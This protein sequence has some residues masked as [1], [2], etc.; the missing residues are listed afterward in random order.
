[1]KHTVGTSPSAEEDYVAYHISTIEGEYSKSRLDLAGLSLL[2]LGCC[3]LVKKAAILRS[4]CNLLSTQAA[5]G[6]AKGGLLSTAHRRVCFLVY[7][8]IHGLVVLSVLRAKLTRGQRTEKDTELNN[9]SSGRSDC[10]HLLQ[11]IQDGEAPVALPLLSRAVG[12]SSLAAAQGDR[13]KVV[14]GAEG[15]PRDGDQGRTE[16]H[17]YCLAVVEGLAEVMDHRDNQ[18]IVPA[19]QDM[20]ACQGRQRAEGPGS[21]LKASH[22][23]PNGPFPKPPDPFM[24]CH[25]ST[26]GRPVRILS[27][28][29]SFFVCPFSCFQIFPIPLPPWPLSFPSPN[30]H[31]LSPSPKRPP[32]AKHP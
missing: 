10:L 26:I 11:R 12:L 32:S 30:A 19:A 1:M 25:K 15:H 28:I 20:E 7:S 13:V 31:S 22:A 21:L 8:K 2:E 17:T 6:Q 24:S 9:S 3:R 14:E 29:E 4:P 18:G 5:A 27:L 16:A 23:F